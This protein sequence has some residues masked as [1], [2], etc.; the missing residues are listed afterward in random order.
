MPASLRPAPFVLVSTS[1]GALI[2]NHNDYQMVGADNAYGVGHQLLANSSY[3]PQ[4]VEFALAM[5]GSR[6]QNFGPGV[7]AVD[8]GANIGVHTVEWARLLH[9]SGTVLAFEA[10]EKIFYALAGNIVLNNCLNVT[11]RHC[12]VGAGCGTAEYD[13]PDYNAPASFGSVALGGAAQQ[14][15]A[16]RRKRVE[17]VS[18]DSLELPRLDFLKIDVEGMELDVLEGAAAS[19]ARFRPQL[20][21]EVL[22]SDAGRIA[23]TL[24]EA[25][26]RTYAAG[27]NLV[28][29]HASD[30]AL[31]RISAAGG[32]LRFA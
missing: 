4:E 17:M 7:A 14:G 31:A 13:E 2:V 32:G 19:L 3:E 29:V 1:H 10:Q 9:G 27:M 16:G 26:Y 20:I 25:G 28:A 15:G 6:L 23:R 22:R 18:L 11:A 5:L 30:P 12:A 21:V 8:C 24:E